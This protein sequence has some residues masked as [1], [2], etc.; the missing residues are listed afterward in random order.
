MTITTSIFIN[1]ANKKHN[2]RYSYNNTN[3][4][5]YHEKIIITCNSHGDFQQTPAKHLAGQNCPKCAMIDSH[6]HL[7]FKWTEKEEN[8]II[9]NYKQ[10]GL[11]L[12]AELLNTSAC[13]TYKKARS[14]GLTKKVKPK[15]YHDKISKVMWN[16][17]LNGAK[18]RRLVV[19]ITQNDIWDLYIKQNKK[20]ALTGSQIT[21][22]K[23]DKINSS[24]DRIDSLR[25]YTKDN[26][27]IV[28]KEINK[29]KMDIPQDKFYE[30]CKTVYLNLKDTM[31]TK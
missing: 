27:Q 7:K 16:S 30:L 9:Q 31:E 13:N 21:L 17:L 25:G 14:M 11:A 10:I 26:I 5:K 19:E 4:F 6:D 29:I 12:T 18:R 1:R 23:N 28:L 20:C 24:V 15:T 3:Y 22:H 8:I 2:N